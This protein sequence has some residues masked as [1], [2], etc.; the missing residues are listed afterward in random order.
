MVEADTNMVITKRTW[1]GFCSRVEKYLVIMIIIIMIL[2][3]HFLSMS[4]QVLPCPFGW[5]C[6]IHWLLL[7]RK[8][9]PLPH[10]EYPGYVTKQS[11][12]EASVVLELSEMCCTPSLL[13]LSCP[14]WPR[15]I[16]PDMVLST[17]QIELNCVFMLNW[18]FLNRTSGRSDNPYTKLIHAINQGFFHKRSLTEPDMRDLL[19]VWHRLSTDRGLVIMD[20]GTIILKSLRR[21]TLHC[22]HAAHQGIDSMK[23][24]A[25]NTVYWPGMNA[26]IHNF[27]A[28]C[29]TAYLC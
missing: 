17:G 21:K 4:I 5:G 25:N 2:W 13:L 16:T 10:N 29:P 24:S 15:L 11:D 9:R 12:G 19:E 20:R 14:L 6:K 26:S 7:C 3:F 27:R 1:K 22:L 8:V 18:I 28:N 23:A